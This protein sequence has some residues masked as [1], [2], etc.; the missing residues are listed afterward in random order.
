MTPRLFVLIFLIALTVVKQNVANIISPRPNSK[1]S[2]KFLLIKL[3]SGYDDGKVK[4]CFIGEMHSIDI[5]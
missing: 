2:G 5:S 3:L 4:Y 1:K